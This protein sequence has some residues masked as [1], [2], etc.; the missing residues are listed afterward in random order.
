MRN[1]FCKTEALPHAPA[2]PV[3]VEALRRFYGGNG[4]FAE[5][6]T[7][8]SES[9]KWGIFRAGVKTPALWGAFLRQLVLAGAFGP[10]ADAAQLGLELFELQSFAHRDEHVAAPRPTRPAPQT[11]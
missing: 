10:V 1:T 5:S 8:R 2:E 3:A 11:M 9:T 7:R 6:L 4:L